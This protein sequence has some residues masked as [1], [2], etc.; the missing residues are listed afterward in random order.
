MKH[1][2]TFSLSALLACGLTVCLP[3]SALAGNYVITIDGKEVEVDEDKEG[4]VTLEN[5]QTVKVLLKKKDIL[6]Y[7]TD[8]F[9]FDHSKHYT[10]AR[11]DL[12]A[13]VFQSML[14]TPIGTAVMIQEYKTLNPANLID[15]MVDELTK[16]EVNYGYKLTESPETMTLADGTVLKGKKVVTTHDE[17]AYTRYILAASGKG[18]GNLF[19][20][21][22][23]RDNEENE[24]EVIDLFWKSL[25]VNLK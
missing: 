4:S 23:E 9:S 2:S 16:E 18:K 21:Q 1:L 13:N 22:I 15:M 6:T 12:G 14:V 10:P 8:S 17:G 24:A 11:T 3:S 7:A 19:I 5:G 20:T 25:K